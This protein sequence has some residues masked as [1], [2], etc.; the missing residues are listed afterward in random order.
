MIAE[1]YGKSMFSFVRN[2]Q[3]VFQS[4]CSILFLP[5]MYESSCCS[6]SCPHLVLSLFWILAILVGRDNHFPPPPSLF[7]FGKDKKP[8]LVG[9]AWKWVCESESN[10]VIFSLFL[11]RWMLTSGGHTVALWPLCGGSMPGT[12]EVFSKYLLAAWLSMIWL[13]LLLKTIR[14]L[15]GEV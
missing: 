2:C 3:P 15:F 4:G 5:A 11:S 9:T 1:T 10:Y 13:P 8:F 12:L 7:S 6:M 14:D